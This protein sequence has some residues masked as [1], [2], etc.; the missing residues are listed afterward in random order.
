M[1]TNS[2][3]SDLIELSGSAAGSEPKKPYGQGRWETSSS[4]SRA[5]ALV[6]AGAKA[7]VVDFNTSS[8][9]LLGRNDLIT[10]VLLHDGIGDIQHVLVEGH[11]RK[12]NTRLTHP[13]GLCE[14]AAPVP[15]I[16]EKTQ[17]P[18]SMMPQ[19]SY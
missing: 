15:K 18:R 13:E 1:C 17:R 9:A 10:A 7:D 8:P 5:Q 3:D 2:K 14:R 16:A 6:A 12:R 11:S 4:S 19:P